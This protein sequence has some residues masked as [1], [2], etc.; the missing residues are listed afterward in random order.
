MRTTN[1]LLIAAMAFFSSGLGLSEAHAEMGK[2]PAGATDV[3][4]SVFGG[5]VYQDGP[6]VN[7][8]TSAP[9]LDPL[10]FAVQDGGFAGAGLGFILD[11]SIA[12]FGLENARIEASFSTHIFDSDGETRNGARLESVDDT[13]VVGNSDIPA[14]ASQKREVYDGVIA[15][16]GEIDASEA[17]DLDGSH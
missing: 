11:D 6:A 2:A 9:E 8:Y 7:A 16:K 3:Y 5:Y 14:R 17:F 15:L 10:A 1:S 13:S 12:P 4:L